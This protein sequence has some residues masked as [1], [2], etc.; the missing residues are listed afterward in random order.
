M[1]NEAGRSTETVARAHVLDI[2]GVLVLFGI[3]SLVFGNPVELAETTW[4]H[5]VACSVVGAFVC[6]RARRRT[7]TRKLGE[8]EHRK[9]WHR[10]VGR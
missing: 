10:F 4:C 3:G 8:Q 5:V 6:W 2:A 1:A 7:A 9:W